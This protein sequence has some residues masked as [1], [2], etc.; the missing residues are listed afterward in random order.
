MTTDAL[1]RL[2]NLRGL[3]RTG[4]AHSVLAQVQCDLQTVI[5]A[6]LELAGHDAEPTTDEPAVGEQ[7]T[8]RDGYLW[9][10]FEDG[11]H[12]W[13]G[14]GWSHTPHTWDYVQDYGPLRATTAADRRRVG[15]PVRDEDASPGPAMA[16]ESDAQPEEVSEDPETENGR[17]NAAQGRIGWLRVEPS[18]EYR[19]AVREVPGGWSD[20]DRDEYLVWTAK[21]WPDAEFTPIRTLADDEVAVKREDLQWAVDAGRLSGPSGAMKRLRAALEAGR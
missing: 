20:T 13:T 21:T 17:E 10:R 11:W 18:H 16:P 1:R 8:D 3:T 4:S 19:H 9:R 15:L 12:L 7:V 5:E 6:V 2:Q 14:E